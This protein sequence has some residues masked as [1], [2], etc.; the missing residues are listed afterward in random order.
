MVY[1]VGVKRKTLC[2]AKEVDTQQREK[3]KAM[4]KAYLNNMG[5]TLIPQGFI[6]FFLFFLCPAFLG[7]SITNNLLSHTTR[8][9]F[10]G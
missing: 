9:V 4:N 7:I 3:E 1:I 10:R 2:R 5:T 8:L 6:A